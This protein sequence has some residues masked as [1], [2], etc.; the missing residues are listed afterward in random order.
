MRRPSGGG[1]RRMLS[2]VGVAVPVAAAVA[3]CLPAPVTA[4]A[5]AT[6]T[7]WTQFV[8]AAA[9]VGAIVW[10][11]ITVAIVRYRRRPADAGSIP[12][13]IVDSRNLE[14][15]WTVLP[16]LTILGLF[17]LT[18]VA[19]GQVDARAVSPRVTVDVTAYRWQWRFDYE[20]TAVSVAGGPDQPA[21]MVVPVGE[22]VHIVLTSVDVAH[23]FFVPAFLF[24]RDAIPGH[25]NEFDVTI[26]EPGVYAGQCAEF[27]G[28]F[29]DRMTLRVRAVPRDVFDTWLAG[30]VPA[31]PSTSA[32]PSASAA[33]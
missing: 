26:D 31:A 18:L 9:V 19:L 28:V 13:Q 29:H 21:E 25:P 8:I 5:R 7:L 11:L 14:I 6:S 33:P 22:P 27:C 17:G 24:K 32:A 10:G 3:G 12:P 1:L 20:G 4:Q 15:A 30:Q 16:I 2:V 23:S